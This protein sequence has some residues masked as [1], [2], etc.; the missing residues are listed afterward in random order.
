MASPGTARARS[1]SLIFWTSHDDPSKY[2]RV[3]VIDFHMLCNRYDP[4]EIESNNRQYTS[5]GEVPAS[6]DAR[7][8]AWSLCEAGGD[9]GGA[10][11]QNPLPRAAL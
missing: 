8:L 10:A 1:S 4:L 3:Y 7:K 5:R 11:G 2:F 6:F 9:E